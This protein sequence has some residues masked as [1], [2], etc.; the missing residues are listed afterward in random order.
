LAPVRMLKNEFFQKIQ[1]IYNR[2]GSKE[3]LVELLGRGRIKKGV[4]E[5]DLRDG[6]LE[7][8][9]VSAIIN[10][11]NSVEEIINEVIYDYKKA[12]ENLFSF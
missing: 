8:G 6:N 3:E 5:G 2:S 11:I 10:S 9:Q 4:F 7:I 1:S 12:Q